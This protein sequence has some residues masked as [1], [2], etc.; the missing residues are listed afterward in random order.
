MTQ[1]VRIAAMEYAVRSGIGSPGLIKMAQEIYDFLA[2]KTPLIA[3]QGGV[4]SSSVQPKI[5]ERA[6]IPPSL[7]PKQKIVLRQCITW[8]IAG[9][10]FTG[11]TLAR[12]F[13]GTGPNYNA[14]LEN[15]RKKG[16]IRRE[17]NK[18]KY[19][20]LYYPDGRK[21][22]TLLVKIPTGSAQGYKPM[23]AKMG[24]ISRVK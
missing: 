14:H 13:K 24:D 9:V 4:S 18:I 19:T 11:A 3:Q 20:P 2:G 7:T 16:Y 1:D 23:T 15:L 10:K 5:A 8:Y 12:H 17:G 6:W 21:V 22:E